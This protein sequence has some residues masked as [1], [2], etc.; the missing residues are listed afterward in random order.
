MATPIGAIVVGF[1]G[2]AD[3]Y[4]SLEWAVRAAVNRRATV[5]LVYALPQ[6]ISDL[7]YSDWEARER[8][9]EGQRILADALSWLAPS[10]YQVTTELVDAPAH[11]ALLAAA[12]NAQ[13]IV[14]GARGHGPVSGLLLG[15][16]SQQVARQ[17]LCPVVVVRRKA[18][19]KAT[20]I[21]VGVDS[22]PSCAGAIGFAFDEASRRN[23]P[24]V[25]VHAW[26]DL[27][28]HRGLGISNSTMTKVAERTASAERLISDALAGW[29]EKFPDVNV[30]WE[31]VPIHPA[32]V[33]ADA[34]E[35]AALVVVGSRGRGPLACLLLGSV[36]QAVLHNAKCPVAI[37][38]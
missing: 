27:T 6:P 2:S 12:T 28:Q 1:N 3:A 23:A 19:S 29:S 38:R 22:S 10:G 17:A 13:L 26:T 34:S 18:D 9:T 16:V 32:T 20:R 25:A 35:H 15:S 30:T 7:P 5:H 14:V 24:L 36:S 11:R 21:V 8:V 4:E 31:A 37:V 33:L